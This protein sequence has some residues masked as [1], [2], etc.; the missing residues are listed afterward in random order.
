MLMERRLYRSRTDTVLGGVASGL[1]KYLNTDP[2]LVRIAWAILVLITNGAALLAY[3]VAWVVVPEEPEVVA[4]ATAPGSADPA[5]AAIDPD[6]PATAVT[7]T[8]AVPATTPE[9]R[10]GGEGRAALIVGVGLIA[11]GAW[12]LLR[13][14]LPP[15]D[16]GLLWPIVLIGIGGVVLVT[17]ARRRGE[18]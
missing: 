13:Q 15:I 7:R 18:G 8:E 10:A 3:L 16:W 9:R 17:S 12:F 14:Y 6:A 5:A 1:A 4:P 11:L 2:A